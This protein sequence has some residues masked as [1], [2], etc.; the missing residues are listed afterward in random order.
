MKNS[1]RLQKAGSVICFAAILI[2]LGI[3][4]VCPLISI[5]SEAVVVDGRFSFNNLIKAFS[6]ADYFKTI[7]N[8][9]LLG[10]SVTLLSSVIALPLAYLFSRTT[11]AKQKWL[12][13][14][15][16]I[17]FMTPPYIAAM[18]WTQFLDKNGFL[19][20]IM[21]FFSHS[22]EFLYS[23]TG[24]TLIMS[25]HVFPFMFTMMKNALLNI[26]SSLEEAAAVSGGGFFYRLRRVLA[27]LLTGN[28]AIAA[29]LVFIKTIGE[30]GT[31][32]VIGSRMGFYVFT[33]SIHNFTTVAPINFGMSA[34]LSSLLTIL[35]FAMWLIQNHITVKRTYKVVGGK[36]VKVTQKKLPV[37]GKIIGITYIALVLFVAVGIPYF[38]VI[39]TSFIKLRSVGLQAGNFTG[40]YYVELFRQGGKGLKAIGVSLFLAVTS[41]TIASALG[42]IICL[43]SRKKNK[44]KKI[45][46][47]VGMVPEMLPSIVLVIGIMLFWN[48][49]Y[50][51]IPLYN[52]LGIMVLAYVVL[53]LPYSIQ[54][55]TSAF[56][57][58][59]DNLPL[60]GRIM[61]GSKTYVFFKITLPLLAKGIISGWMMIFIISFRELITASLIAPTNTLVVSTFIM[62]QFEQ[63]EAQLGM[64][65]AVICLLITVVALAIVKLLT[66]RKKR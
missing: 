28:Y 46:E 12:D 24:L 63:G 23:F 18:G 30:Y 9:L 14:V 61:G 20:Q 47:A 53:F 6:E 50:K 42:T 49:I 41:A 40:E 25:L 60:A 19:E 3:L 21:P 17:P 62:R 26:P 57:Q 16:M 1:V 45:P 37:W 43:F 4:I 59:G 13:I 54:Y 51:A 34:M 22:S 52:T 10:L 5:L 65:M 56:S 29:I 31:P 32:A 2:V 35:C 55:V 64:C 58:F 36:G 33:T 66:E 15:F 38:S 44:L 8:S 11:F 27:P 7:G 48:A 39:T